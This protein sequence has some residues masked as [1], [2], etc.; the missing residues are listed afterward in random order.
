MSGSRFRKRP[1]P[2][3]KKRREDIGAAAADRWWANHMASSKFGGQVP[4]QKPPPVCKKSITILQNVPPV[5][6]WVPIGT[7]NVRM[8]V[9]LVAASAN[10]LDMVQESF[11]L[12]NESPTEWTFLGTT[13]QAGF[14]QLGISYDYLAQIWTGNLAWFSTTGRIY[15]AIFVPP[16]DVPDFPWGI[17]TQ[18]IATMN[19]PGTVQAIYTL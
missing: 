4:R 8:F 5:D 6:P 9:N 11:T 16:P 2:Q 15:S 1:A 3:N 18:T 12:A 19:D 17:T 14:I 10:P 13:A 7:T